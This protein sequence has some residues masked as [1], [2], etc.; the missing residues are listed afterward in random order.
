VVVV[1]GAERQVALVVL[2]IIQK[3][4]EEPTRRGGVGRG[5]RSSRRSRIRTRR[6]RRRGRIVRGGGLRLGRRGE[7]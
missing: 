5:G 1:T 3:S 2:I 4:I 6:V 7:G